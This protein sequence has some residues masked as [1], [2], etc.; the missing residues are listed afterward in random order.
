MKLF[1]IKYLTY[2]KN[3]FF[4]IA[5]NEERALELAPDCGFRKSAEELCSDTSKEFISS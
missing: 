4:I 3:D 2:A 1:R 5:E